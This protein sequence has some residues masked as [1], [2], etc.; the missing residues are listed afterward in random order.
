MAFRDPT[1]AQPAGSS[2]VSAGPVHGGPRVAE[3]L[4]RARRRAGPHQMGTGIEVTTRCRLAAVRR[5]ARICDQRLNAPIY[6]NNSVHAV[7]LLR[8]YQEEGLNLDKVREIAGRN[9][10]WRLMVGRKAGQSRW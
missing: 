7:E 10:L 9:K 4:R 6:A 1:A 5:T 2:E 3:N 8:R